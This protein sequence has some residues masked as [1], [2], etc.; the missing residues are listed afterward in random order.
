MKTT[1]R[2]NLRIHLASLLLECKQTDEPLLI[3]ST[4]KQA[5]PMIVISQRKY[6][7]MQTKLDKQGEGE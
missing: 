5:N 6:D 1:T 4:T 2:R 3:L 7:E